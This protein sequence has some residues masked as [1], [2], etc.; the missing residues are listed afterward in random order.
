MA[1]PRPGRLW[2]GHATT[3]SYCA[4]PSYKMTLLV[5]ANAPKRD[6]DDAPSA[7]IIRYRL[8]TVNLDLGFAIN[9]NPVESTNGIN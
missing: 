7:E 2:L 5:A 9:I 8:T 3:V 4:P 1:G 6:S